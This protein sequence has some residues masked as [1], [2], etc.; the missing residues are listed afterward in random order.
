LD[1][2][3]LI[4]R[5]ETGR[6]RTV[7][8]QGLLRRW[9]QDAPLASRGRR[10]TLLEPRGLTALGAKLRD[11]PAPNAV[12]GSLAAARLA[13]IAPPRLATIYVPDAGRAAEQL[14]LRPT[15]AGANVWLIEPK[16]DFV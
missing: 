14:G 16:D 4:T 13:P 15:D 11:L 6:P 7:D 1:D 9:A 3:A 12:T 10:T 5:S 2:E 8:W